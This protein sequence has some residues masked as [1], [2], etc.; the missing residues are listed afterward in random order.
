M[1]DQTPR[2]EPIEMGLTYTEAQATV[3]GRVEMV[4][5]GL[6]DTGDGMMAP[7]GISVR[8]DWCTQLGHTSWKVGTVCLTGAIVS[9]DGGPQERISASTTVILLEDQWPEWVGHFVRDCQPR[10]V[11]AIG[12]QGVA[13]QGNVAARQK[14][15]RVD[16]PQARMTQVSAT[17]EI[18]HYIGR[19]GVEGAPVVA[20]R[21][22]GVEPQRY[23]RPETLDLT[24]LWGSPESPDGWRPATTK[25]TGSFTDAEGIVQPGGTA[26]TLPSEWASGY[27]AAHVPHHIRL[28]EGELS[29]DAALRQFTDTTDRYHR[30]AS[31]RAEAENAEDPSGDA[32]RLC[33]AEDRAAVEARVAAE[34]LVG[35]LNDGQPIPQAWAANPSRAV[36][37]KQWTLRIEAGGEL[38]H[39]LVMAAA[40]Q[41][42]IGLGRGASVEVRNAD[43]EQIAW[44][45]HSHYAE[46]N[47][48]A[49]WA[50]QAQRQ[51]RNQ[52]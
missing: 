10:S 37:T 39:R 1:T 22:D 30:V 18:R 8:Y 7:T 24:Y 9:A 40:E 35:L 13:Q 41:L 16:Y 20:L 44:L 29:T 6:V 25:M 31:R 38:A 23:M 49:R 28:V 4:G 42:A 45:P 19:L 50:A 48:T 51:L 2:I 36:E 14:L 11:L 52:G 47:E 17:Y 32:A 26:Q 21:Q 46:L 15:P 3:T 12:A 43:G 5:T 27:I 34:H 33:E